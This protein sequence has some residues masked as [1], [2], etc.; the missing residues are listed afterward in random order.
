MSR[1]LRIVG[2]VAGV[3]SSIAT[4]VGLPQVAIAAAAVAPIADVAAPIPERPMTAISIFD[5]GRRAYIAADG[6][7]YCTQTGRIV[8]LGTKVAAAPTLNMAI[9]VQGC[10]GPWEISAAIKR[11]CEATSQSV[12]LRAM[13]DVLRSLRGEM[14]AR[15]PDQ[16]RAG[17][18]ETRLWIAA[19]DRVRCKPRLFA[20]ASDHDPTAPGAEPFELREI[21]GQVTGLTG[22]QVATLLPAGY[23]T[24]PKADARRILQAQRHYPF[25]HLNGGCGVAG[26]CELFT[27]SR[28]G[29]ASESIL[30][31]PEGLGEV[32]DPARAGLALPEV[33]ARVEAA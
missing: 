29:V 24:D 25:P 6:G 30:Q 2:K 33:P 26:T 15:F 8:Q 11:T 5:D 12:V 1:A 14:R 32:P 18:N 9:A 27:V 10:A 21:K 19:Y 13:P 28:R 23:I 3:V 22:D 20:I 31:F 7:A 17:W 4:L 16:D